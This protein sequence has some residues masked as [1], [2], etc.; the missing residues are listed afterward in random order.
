MGEKTV[1]ADTASMKR[2]SSPGSRPGLNARRL[3]K[4]PVDITGVLHGVLP[5]GICQ[6]EV[7]EYFLFSII[8]VQFY[9]YEKVKC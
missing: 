4:T 8:C 1:R 3:D 2:A 5:W 7:V 6:F 9:A